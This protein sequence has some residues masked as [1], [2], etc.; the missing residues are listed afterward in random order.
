MKLCYCHDF[1]SFQLFPLHLYKTK[2]PSL[3]ES[4]NKPRGL[5][6]GLPFAINNVLIKEMLSNQ[7]ESSGQ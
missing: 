2:P 6:T 7:L 5:F 4:R 1:G 3:R